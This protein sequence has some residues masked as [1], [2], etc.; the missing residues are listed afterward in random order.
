VPL[1]ILSASGIERV[2]SLLRERVG[3]ALASQA[4][5]WPLA[6]TA[7]ACLTFV[8]VQL[9]SLRLMADLARAPYDLVA[10]RGLDRAL[11]FVHNLP[12]IHMEPGAWVYYHRNP[13][14]DLSDRVLF[15]RDLGPER[16]RI[17]A[18]HLAPR[19]PYVMGMRGGKLVLEPLP[20]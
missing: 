12:A 1:A 5:A 20:P 17:L 2:V 10:E 3:A 19:A 7:A 4:L 16:D 13:E 6:A 9:V 14:P 11:V 18:A 8:P 15:V